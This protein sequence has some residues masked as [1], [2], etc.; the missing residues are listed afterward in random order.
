MATICK[1]VGIDWTKEYRT[2]D[3]RPIRI[4]DKGKPVAELFG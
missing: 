1:A 2:P 4:T 3:K